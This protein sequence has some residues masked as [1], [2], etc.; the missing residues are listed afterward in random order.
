ML[1]SLPGKSFELECTDDV[2]KTVS[3]LKWTK[4]ADKQLHKLNHDCNMTGG[5]QSVLVLAIG[6][7]DML[8]RNIDTKKGLVNGS[9]GKVTAITKQFCNCTI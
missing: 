9:L 8:C 7:R 5:L 3:T 4:T 2:D 1:K 6:A